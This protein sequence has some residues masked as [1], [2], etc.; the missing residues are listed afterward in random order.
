MTLIKSLESIC[1]IVLSLWSSLG[2]VAENYKR[3]SKP[4][5]RS[6]KGDKMWFSVGKGHLWKSTFIILGETSWG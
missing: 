4:Q 2:Q 3:R 5:H 6:R 1:Y